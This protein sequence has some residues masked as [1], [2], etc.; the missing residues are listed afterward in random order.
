MCLDED[1]DTAM[2]AAGMLC[3]ITG[4]SNKCCL[5][6]FDS[7]NWLDCLHSML[8]NP[9]LQM[10]Y[11]GVCVMHNIVSASK[12]CAEKLIDTDILEI[13]MALSKLPPYDGREKIVE[14]AGL[15]LQEAERWGVIKKPGEDDDD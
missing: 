1:K 14:I 15:T 7:K 6:M 9:D 5:K 3:I 4:A 11:R 13:M 8:L 2:A 12:E 10:Q